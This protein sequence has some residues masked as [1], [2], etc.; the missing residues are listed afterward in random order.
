[1][2]LGRRS[3]AHARMKEGTQ[4][5]AEYGWRNPE[6]SEVETAVC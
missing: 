5:P 1:M 2:D 6:S 4:T 3:T